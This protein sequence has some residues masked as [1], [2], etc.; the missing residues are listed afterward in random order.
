[1][2]RILICG[3]RHWK[4]YAE[5]LFCLERIE[6][7][8]NTVVVHGCCRGADSM[9]NDAA[10]RLGIAVDPYPVHD[11]D[12]ERLGLRAGPMRNRRML[13][14]LVKG[15]DRVIAFHKNVHKSKGTKDMINQAVRAGIRV[16]L[17]NG[18]RCEEVTQ[19]IPR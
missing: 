11:R 14:T 13:G 18:E 10:K 6:D 2:H 4:D 1:M 19:E 17:C 5:I 3:D 9:A 8:E 16:T 7:R 12:W 15:R